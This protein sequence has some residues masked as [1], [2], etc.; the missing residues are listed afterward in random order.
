M[1]IGGGFSKLAARSL[2]PSA[3]GHGVSPVIAAPGMVLGATVVA[4][5]SVVSVESDA[6]TVLSSSWPMRRD[7]PKAAASATTTMRPMRITFLRVVLRRCS[8]S[9]S[10]RR[11]WRLAFCRSR[12]SVPTEAA[13]Y[14]RR[15]PAEHRPRAAASGPCPG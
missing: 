13:G 7:S 3:A 6:S 9:S 10:A 12:L 5:G 2:E 4:A 11:A 15:R 14:R 1:H 8:R